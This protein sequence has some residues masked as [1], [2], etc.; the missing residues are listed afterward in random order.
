MRESDRGGV[1][2]RGE[3]DQPDHPE[4]AQ[5]A[6]ERLRKVSFSFSQFYSLSFV[7]FFLSPSP[8]ALSLTVQNTLNTRKTWKSFFLF[9]SYLSLS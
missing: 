9:V 3:D 8:F 1:Q 6:G 5:H 4:H 2:G 7:R